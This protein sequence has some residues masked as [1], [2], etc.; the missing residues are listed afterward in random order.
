MENDPGQSCEEESMENTL[1]RGRVYGP[2]GTLAPGHSAEVRGLKVT[3]E[4]LRRRKSSVDDPWKSG[5][6]VEMG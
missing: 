1:V 6:C 4:A 2:Y 5:H 3:L